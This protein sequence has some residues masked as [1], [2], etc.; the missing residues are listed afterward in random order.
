M[1]WGLSV[2]FAVLLGQASLAVA[3]EERPPLIV[4][5]LA[6]QGNRRVQD[7]VIWGRVETRVGSPFVSAR[8]AEDVRRIFA[9]GFFDDVQV[10]VE[11]FE[12]GIKLTFVVVERPFVRDIGFEGNRR[13]ATRDL[14]AL[15][16]IQLGTIY[17]PV[18]VQRARERLKAHYEAGGHLEAEIAPETEKLQDGDVKVIFRIAEGR[19]FTIDRIVIQGTRG[20]SERQV[21]AAMQTQ[22]RW[23]LILGGILHRRRLEDDLE[24][25][26]ALYQDRGYIR[27]RVEGYEVSVDPVRGRVTITI[28]VVEGPQFTVG[29]VEAPGTS[30]LP[31]E[32]VRRQIRL[33]PGEVFSRAKLRES[34][35]GILDLYGA[36]G[37]ACAE[38]SVTLEITD[39]S[40]KSVERVTSPARC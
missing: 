9:L 1:G 20:L 12:G 17:N 3:Q 35:Q 18:D 2:A 7:A 37:R 19:R 4:G 16:D 24:R 25:I 6:L 36:I 33:A 8:L 13:L 5:E 14:Q 28:K 23:F 34:L 21:K 30:A 27:A 38:V 39:G 31:L 22:E 10:K 26:V 40:E 32:E 29:Q 15:I 11:E